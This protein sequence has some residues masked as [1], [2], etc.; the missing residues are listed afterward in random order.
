MNPTLTKVK[1]LGPLM[2]LFSNIS[3]LHKLG[4]LLSLAVF[5]TMLLIVEKRWYEYRQTFECSI[6]EYQMY[7][8]GMDR[9][10]IGEQSYQPNWESIADSLKEEEI[11]RFELKIF[12]LKSDFSEKNSEAYFKKYKLP[13]PSSV[14]LKKFGSSKAIGK[15]IGAGILIYLFFILLE[16]YR[17]RRSSQQE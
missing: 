3:A 11:R 7:K 13:K 14:S 9:A 8:D 12:S 5:L 1:Y 15:S 4:I 16:V 17:S 10:R 6:N 2:K